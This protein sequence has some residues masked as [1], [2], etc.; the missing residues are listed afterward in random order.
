M[1]T[2]Q[3]YYTFTCPD[4]SDEDDSDEDEHISELACHLV[5]DM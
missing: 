4:D 3:A 1:C 2:T 5:R